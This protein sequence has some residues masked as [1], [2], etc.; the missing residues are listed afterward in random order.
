MSH[1]LRIGNEET[2]AWSNAF[3]EKECQDII[4]LALTKELISGKVVDYSSED[5]IGQEREIRKSKIRWLPTTEDDNKWI[6]DRLTLQILDINQKYFQFDLEYIQDLQFTMYDPT[7]SYFEK[8]VDNFYNYS[9]S[10]RKLTFSV[11]LSS[12]DDYE[13][14]DFKLHCQR[15]P[16]ILPK[17]RGVMSAFP[18]PTLHEIVPVTKGIRY[19]L[20]GWVAGP[21]FR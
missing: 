7:D 11:Q 14:G 9:G 20:V 17:T 4:D 16:V 19:S 3:T 8:H 2:W 1:Y 21:K 10:P 18:S 5:I 6:Y 12:P 15:D 13:G